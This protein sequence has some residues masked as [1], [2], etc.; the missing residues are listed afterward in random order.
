MK[1]WK[2]WQICLFTLFCLLLNF[3]GNSLS[4][5]FQLPVWLD[6]FGTVLCAWILGPVC[7]AFVGITSNLILT[8]VTPTSFAYGLTSIILAVAVGYGVRRKAFDSFLG[9]LQ[10]SLITILAS[11]AVSSVVNAF[12]KY[13]WTGNRFGDAVIEYLTELGLPFRMSAAVGQLYLEFLDKLLTILFL[14]AC[15]RLGH[16]LLY[17]MQHSRHWTDSS[18]PDPKVSADKNSSGVKT[19]VMLLVGGSLLLTLS[20]SSAM[21][22]PYESKE[23]YNDYIQTIYSSS[24]G[25]PCGEANDIA[26][27][28]DGVLWV[29]TY[30]G[31]YRYNGKEFRQLDSM[32]IVRNANCLYVDEEGRLWIGTNDNGLAIAINE[33]IVNVIDEDSGLPSNSVRSIVRGSDGYYYVG[34]SSSLQIL[35]MNGGL[36][37]L[38]TL[39]EMN[40]ISCLSSDSRGNVAGVSSNGRLFLLNGG[41]ILCSLQLVEEADQYNCCRFTPTGSL[42]VGTTS[43]RLLTFRVADGF[44]EQ[45]D[46]RICEG[47]NNIDDLYFTPAGEMFVSADNGIGYVDPD[48][49]FRSINTNEFNNSID[50][51][52]MDY[53][54]NLWFTSSRL[55]LLRLAPSSFRDIYSVA[56]MPNRV[57]NAVEKW[58]GKFYFGTDKGL[59]AVDAETAL[60]ETDT[61]TEQFDGVR[62]RCL[63]TDSRNCLWICTYGKG[64]VEVYPD[65]TQ[66]HYN[67]ANGSFGDWA[68]VVKEL[69]DGTILAAGDSG[70]S[71]IRDD[72]VTKT[73]G[74]ANGLINSM[75][76]SVTELSD[77]TVIAGTDGDGLAVIRD[78]EVDRMLTRRD[79]LSS[80]VILR[81]VADTKSEG[82]FLVTSNGLCFLE[83]D[84]SI[85]QLDRFPYFNNYDIWAENEDTLFVMSSAGLYIADRDG[86]LATD[87]DTEFHWQLLDVRSGLN[88]SLTA[89]S[90]SYYDTDGT[91]YL[92]C[93]TGVFAMD[94]DDYATVLPAYRMTIPYIRLNGTEYKT[95][96]NV[97]IEVSRGITRIELVPEVL[98]Y[99]VQVPNIGYYL[100]GFDSEWTVMPQTALNTIVY[101][102]LPA[103]NYSL[104]LAVFD[105]DGKE[106]VAERLFQL[107][108][109]ES[110]HET[111]LFRIYLFGVL[112]LMVVF[113]AGL[114]GS[115][116]YESIKRQA[117]MGNQ[118]IMAIARAVDAK[119]PRTSQHSERVARYSKL[120]ATAMG[121]KERDCE[122]I[123]KAAMMHDIGKIG[124]PDEVLKKPGRL[125]E[126]E[127]AQ[128]KTHT[129]NGAEI[130]KD[131]TLIDHVVDGA[132]Y[133]HERPDGR[134]YPYGLTADEIPEYARIIGVADAFDAMTANRVYRKQ[135]DFG[136]VVNEMRKGR[137]TQFDPEA[138]D[139][140]LRLIENGTIDLYKIYGVS[141]EEAIKQSAEGSAEDLEAKAR[142]EAEK[143]AGK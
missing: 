111:L 126:E 97:P 24:N 36:R 52:L 130:L 27:T 39:S 77:G 5:L 9:A 18:G 59:D 56:G 21:A 78:G 20:D 112:L 10:L 37:R 53:Q 50:R 94:A 76:L 57:V 45:T 25:L 88:S 103:G 12:L 66:K 61:L 136:Y 22:A 26:Q 121:M 139:T 86:L 138:D 70:L 28:T 89:N 91:L 30:A 40:Y 54:G 2:I 69:S 129:T 73:I 47:F 19:A 127:Y 133:H 105:S 115:S 90:W 51:M 55:G 33:K 3:A 137:G 116:S 107:N 110:F 87:E 104:H 7:G 122:N 8:A 123:R 106:V 95:E 140:L 62:I 117:E 43:N 80:G 98:N 75:I 74:H 72:T 79:G 81:T 17:R 48:G 44:L 34:T 102:N 113:A 58:Q 114:I 120:I 4:M 11:F 63:L 93:D 82:V 125:T 16:R 38:G 14:F 41:Q 92:P 131:I 13:G 84:F 135:M 46:E 132:L 99:S 118:A 49:V 124:I 141:P 108:K 65:G 101:T 68:R 32:N 83:E 128:M 100:E 6:S 134:G 15:I 96:R 29:G 85:R 1:T 31:L 67:E 35:T 119:D 143:E 71:F 42:I 142:A 109:S 64:L 60:R 23:N